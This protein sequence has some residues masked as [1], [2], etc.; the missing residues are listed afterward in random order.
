[1]A[2][3]QQGEQHIAHH[4]LLPD[5]N[6]RDGL[7]N[8]ACRVGGLL[9]GKG[10]GHNRL[11]R[12]CSRSTS[13]VNSCSE[14]ALPDRAW[15]TWCTGKP[16][17]VAATTARAASVAASVWRASLRCTCLRSAASRSSAPPLRQMKKAL[18]CRWCRKSRRWVT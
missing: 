16:V 6:A 1:M 2:I 5:E 9:D 3:A 14:R 11:L 13:S 12:V 10:F 7:F 8:G 4:L 15:A 17:S 18:A